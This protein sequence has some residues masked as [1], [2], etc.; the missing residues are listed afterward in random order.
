MNL[1]AFVGRL[2]NDVDLK[3]YRNTKGEERA[4]AN[5]TL[6][7]DDGYGDN[8]R[9]MFAECTVF[10]KRAETL[11]KYTSKGSKIGVTASGHTETWE[12]KDGNKHSAI[13]F[14]VSDFEFLDV[15]KTTDKSPDPNS[16]RT[17][18]K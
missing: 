18:R 11:E 8:K 16:G 9:T 15:K 1:C 10:G 4:I 13:R 5:F 14:T 3:F 7:V 2:T 12:G 6:A 17:Y